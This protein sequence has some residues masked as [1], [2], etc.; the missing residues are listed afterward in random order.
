MKNV[1]RI[2]FTLSLVIL[3]LSLCL[4]II[5]IGYSGIWLHT[6]NVF[7][8]R[9]KVADIELSE[10]KEDDGGQYVDVVYKEYKQPTGLES[11]LGISSIKI[12]EKSFKIYGDSIYIG[13]PI[14]KF[15]DELTLFNF[16]TMYKLAKIYGRYSDN[17]QEISRNDIALTSYS[18]DLNDGYG[19]WKNV[20]EVYRSDSFVGEVYR[21][22]IDTTQLSEPGQFA[23]NR[24][25]KYELYI[26]NSGFIWEY[27]E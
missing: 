15:K 4:G 18:Y 5:S 10:L 14:L 13:G 16:K 21:Q 23:T 3:F 1:M 20:F 7:T 8:E 17:N 2:I 25:L 27:V 6:Y 9:T 26:A 22:F 24:L 12:S 11:V 19:D